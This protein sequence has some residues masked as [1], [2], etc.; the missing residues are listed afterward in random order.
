ML[1]TWVSKKGVHHDDDGHNIPFQLQHRG[2]LFPP[3]TESALSRSSGS[4]V[5]HEP[6]PNNSFRGHFQASITKADETTRYIYIICFF[7]HLTNFQLYGLVREHYK[8]TEAEGLSFPMMSCSQ[9]YEVVDH[10]TERWEAVQRCRSLLTHISWEN[11]QRDA[12][13]PLPRYYGP[14][15]KLSIDAY[16]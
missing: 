2:P 14:H 15:S 16:C 1:V 9:T 10:E 3:L 13:K 11:E 7:C 5:L 4:T 6:S 8:A 12:R